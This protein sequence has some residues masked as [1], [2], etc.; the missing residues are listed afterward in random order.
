MK[1]NVAVTIAMSLASIGFANGKTPEKQDQPKKQLQAN[2]KPAPSAPK[3][4][5]PSGFGAITLGMTKAEVEALQS[6][7]GVYLSSKMIPYV[8]KNVQPKEGVDQFDALIVTPL[9]TAP[10]KTALTFSEGKLTEL[11]MGIDEPS[12]LLDH[13]KA[14]ITEKY[15]DGKVKDDRKEEQCIYKNGANFKLTTGLIGVEWEQNLSAGE[16]VL[17][18]LS[19][20]K[21]DMCPSNLSN[22]SIGAISSRG[23]TILKINNKTTPSPKNLF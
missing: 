23:L 5:G 1:I 2:V 21:I 6:T 17:T 10:L 22:G 18:R 8:R 7:D 4:T 9:S 15:G 20:Y 11:Y 12:N 19:D 13:I 16:R 3:A 14:Q